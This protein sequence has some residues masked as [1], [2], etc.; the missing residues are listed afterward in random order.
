MKE[1]I[2]QR[3]IKKAEKGLKTVEYLLT[4]DDAPTDIIAFHCQQAVEKYLKV[5]LTLVD[6]RVKKTHDL[7]T[8]LAF[9]IERDNKV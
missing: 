9:C 1:E 8:I 6:V 7:E 4:F 3:L 5:Y 2:V